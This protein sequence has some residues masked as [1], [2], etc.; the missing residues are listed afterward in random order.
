MHLPMYPT[1]VTISIHIG[2]ESVK[3]VSVKSGVC[4]TLVYS[5]KDCTYS[6]VNILCFAWRYNLPWG[7]SDCSTKCCAA[8][9]S[10]PH[11]HTWLVLKLLVVKLCGPKAMQL[12]GRVGLNLPICTMGQASSY[13][14]PQH[15]RI[16]CDS[17]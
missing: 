2:S 15:G 9:R 13:P 16:S 11:T 6:V 4:G 12:Y 10:W 1:V 5:S 17:R 7:A 14:I 8:Q 3:L